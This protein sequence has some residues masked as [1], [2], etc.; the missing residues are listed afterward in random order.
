MSAT[1]EEI[2]AFMALE[3]PQTKCVVE[4]VNENGATLSHEIGINE[5]RPG[6]TVS[7]PVMMA[8]ADVAIYVAILGRIGIVPLTVTTSLTIN[9]L[10][11]PSA[12]SRIIAECT[13]LK[14]GRTLIVGE[15]SLY[16][17]GSDDVVAHVVGTYSVPPKRS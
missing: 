16:S 17:E 9:F 11:K 5:L 15:V 8:V 3:F 14:V 1:K 7:G 12:D 6:G 4:A 13:L 2:S 10:R